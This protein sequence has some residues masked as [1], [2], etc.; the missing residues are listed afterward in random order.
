MTLGK[1]AGASI[2]IIYSNLKKKP[3]LSTFKHLM[4]CNSVFC[5][6]SVYANYVFRSL[7][8]TPLP[9]FHR[10]NGLIPRV[11]AL[12]FSWGKHVPLTP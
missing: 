9:S 1:C 4:I 8:I 6:F 3:G 7:V 12:S 11:H 2:I 5:L 10:F